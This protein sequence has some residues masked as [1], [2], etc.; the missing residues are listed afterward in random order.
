MSTAYGLICARRGHREHRHILYRRGLHA[1]RKRAWAICRYHHASMIRMLHDHVSCCRLRRPACAAHL[2][3]V[4]INA[5]APPSLVHIFRI[6]A[7]SSTYTQMITR[8]R[9]FCPTRTRVN[10]RHPHLRDP[11]CLRSSRTPSHPKASGSNIN[12][13][14]S[15]RKSTD[16]GTAQQRVVRSSATL[17]YELTHLDT[18]AQEAIDEQLRNPDFGCTTTTAPAPAQGSARIIH[19]L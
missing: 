7:K 9:P 17:T 15:G 11:T 19:P 8:R 1:R 13:V 18:L 4:D 6:C 10:G 14:P 3:S 2:F 16:A 5:V 12:T